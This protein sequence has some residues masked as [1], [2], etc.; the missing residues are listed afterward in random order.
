MVCA[1]WRLVL[2]WTSRPGQIRDIADALC[3]GNRTAAIGRQGNR[4]FLLDSLSGGSSGGGVAVA[5][6]GGGN[7]GGGNTTPRVGGVV[8]VAVS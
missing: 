6:N 3:A 2:R 5:S 4:V 8:E 7:G 1:Y